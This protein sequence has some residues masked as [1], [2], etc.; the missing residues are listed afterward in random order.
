MNELQNFGLMILSVTAYELVVAF[1]LTLLP[2]FGGAG[3]RI[4]AAIAQ[5]PLL[6][7]AISALTWIPWL[8]AGLIFGWLGVLASV[9]GQW[10]ALQIWTRTHEAMHWKKRKG[11]RIVKF[12][13]REVGW[14]ANHVA[15]WVTALAVPVFLLVRLAQIALYPFLVRLLDFPKYRTREWIAVSRH[16]FDGLIGHD[17]IWCLYCDWMT[18]VYALGAEMLRN[19]ESFWCPIRF[20]DPRKCANCRVDFPDIDGGWVPATANMDA[21][22]RVMSEKYGDGARSWFGHPARLTVEGKEPPAD[23]SRMDER[24]PESPAGAEASGEPPEAADSEAPR[25][26]DTRS[27]DD[28]PHERE[29]RD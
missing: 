4:A 25:H 20:D 21:V 26:A 16:K 5:A 18:G 3:K 1:G 2:R 7:A 14:F 19:V 29:R 22:A 6:D 27:R 11:P 15:L 13:N 9:L 28:G 8:V 12:L 24:S 10:V 23:S 17:L